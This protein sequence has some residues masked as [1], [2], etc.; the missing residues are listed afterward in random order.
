MRWLPCPPE[1]YEVVTNLPCP[2]GT[3]LFGIQI[4]EGVFEICAPKDTFP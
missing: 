3:S 4:L 2:L 1:L